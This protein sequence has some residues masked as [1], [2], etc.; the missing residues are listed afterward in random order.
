VERPA[1]GIVEGHAPKIAG[2]KDMVVA[3]LNDF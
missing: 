2:A 1:A 3:Q